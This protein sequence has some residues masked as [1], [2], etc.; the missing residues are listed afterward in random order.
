MGPA[1]SIVLPHILQDI[2]R[3]KNPTGS[4]IEAVFQSGTHNVELAATAKQNVSG[5]EEIMSISPIP[6]YLVYDGFNHD[7]SVA[8]VY[9]RL[10]ESQNDSPM[11]YHALLL[12]HS[13]MLGSCRNTDTKTFAPH[14]E[15][16]KMI[17]T[18]VRM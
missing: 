5:K 18:Q 11:R 16:Y 9:E 2:I 10:R 14:G 13:Y 17:P 8:L 4:K 6:A 1:Q 12:L 3:V 7:I 15:F